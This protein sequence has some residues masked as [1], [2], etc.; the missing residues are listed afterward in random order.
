MLTVQ[1]LLDELDLELA[2]GADAAAAPV[3]WVHISELED[4]TPWLSG[5]ELMLTTGIPLDTAAKQRAF[6][7]L[8]ADRNLAGLGFGT[9][10]NHKSLPKALVD[11]AEKRGLPALRGALLGAVHRDH[12]EGLRAP[13]QRA[14]RGAAAGDRGAAPA[15][16]AGPRGARP[17][18]NRRHRRLRGRRHRR[19]PRRPRRAARRQGFRRQLSAE[20][21]AGDPQGS[22]RPRRR[23]PPLRPLPPH[24][25]RAGAGPPG[26]LPRRRPAAGLGGDR[27]RLRRPRRLRAADPAA[28]GRGGGAG[29][30]APPRRPAR[31]SGAW[32]ATSS[33]AALGGRMDADR[34]APPAR[35]VRDRRGGRGARLRPRRP[36]PRRPRRWKRRSPPTPAPPSSPPT[37]A[38]AASCSAR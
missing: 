25:R 36:R 19:D 32:P 7:R 21:I 16:A 13:R 30:D 20:A 27:P 26:D 12:R 15:R 29:A 14:V 24:G 2:A 35:A 1:S 9:G 22:A 6:I 37:A 8:L 23:R 38:A 18:G 28:G 4:P 11:E 10:F 33:P 3:R 31:P 34:A 17:G 5:G